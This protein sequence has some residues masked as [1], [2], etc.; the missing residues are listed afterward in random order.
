MRDVAILPPADRRALFTNTASK[1]GMTDAIIEKDF[2]V[3]WML[4]YLFHRSKWKD[5]LAFKGGTGLSKAY[6]L[7]ERFSEDLDIVLDWRVLGFSKDEPWESRS[8]TK[9]DQF[10]R[11]ANDRTV[12]FL[13]DEFVPTVMADL[14]SELGSGVHIKPDAD[15]AQTILLTYP[16]EFSDQTILQEIRL[17]I[18]AL[19][20]W[21]P[22]EQK[23]IIPYAAEHY[24]HLFV[25]PST[26]VLTVRP[27]RTFWEKATILHHEANRPANSLMPERYSR[28]YYDM[29]RL[30]MSW[31]KGKALADL[32]LLRKVV[33]FKI[34]SYPRSWARYEHATPGSINLM[35]PPQRL[36]NLKED[37]NYMLGMLFGQKPG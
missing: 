26:S 6:G 4:D 13:K 1:A 16:Q 11:E 30:S 24:R 23:E 15:D 22:A 25:E 35:P 5:H 27:E 29:Y 36:D 3:C 34:K 19:A 12:T 21:T 28:H 10:N 33:N 18:G 7:V 17:E 8:N 31:V 9:Q 37:Y 32:D 2:W 14:S 20:V